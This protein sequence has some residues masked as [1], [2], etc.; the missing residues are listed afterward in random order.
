M[1]LDVF[2]IF[3]ILEGVGSGDPERLFS[4]PGMSS[5]QLH[6]ALVGPHLEYWVH[7]WSPRCRKDG[8]LLERSR[9]VSPGRPCLEWWTFVTRTGGLFSLQEAER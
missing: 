4:L 2:P 5:V 9:R 8:A 7:F 6:R 1:S 3:N